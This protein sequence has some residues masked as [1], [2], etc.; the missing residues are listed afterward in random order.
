MPICT[1]KIIYC[2]IFSTILPHSAFLYILTDCVSAKF[3]NVFSIFAELILIFM[4][5]TNNLQIGHQYSNSEDFKI[6]KDAQND[7]TMELPFSH[8]HSFYAIYWIHEGC[9]THVIDFE[10]YEFKP[11]RLFYIQPEQVHFLYTGS[12]IR[13]S[14]LQFT[15]YFMLANTRHSEIMNSYKIAVYKDLTKQEQE[16]VQKLFDLIYDESTRALPNSAIIQSK[17]NTLL[18]EL[19]RISHCDN[20]IQNIPDILLKYRILINERFTQSKQ[21]QEYATILGITP[22]YLNVLARKYLGQSA[23][24]MINER[25]VLETKRLLLRTNDDISEIAYKLGFNELS[26]FSRFFKHNTGIS[27]NN[28]RAEMNKM[29]HK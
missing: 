20:T 2:L 26:Y 11:N 19:E 9:G 12:Y 10:D 5:K 3:F 18:L 27:P 13:Y 8:R 29:Y 22:N 4:L 16:R 14:A 15:E 17:I 28:F 7:P 6:E 21:V 1:N 25:I 24:N 23:L